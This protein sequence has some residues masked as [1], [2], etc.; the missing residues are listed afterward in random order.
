M[1]S[2]THIYA[3]RHLSIHVEVLLAWFC[4]AYLVVTYSELA[5]ANALV[6]DFVK[7]LVTDW[8]NFVIWFGYLFSVSVSLVVRTNSA[9]RSKY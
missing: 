5:C 2:L 7:V 8:A 6:T 9:V 3:L 4:Q 1:F